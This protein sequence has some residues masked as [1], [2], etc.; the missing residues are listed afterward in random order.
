MV[1]LLLQYLVQNK[2]TFNVRIKIVR[3]P[4]TLR[5][6]YVFRR[7]DT[8]DNM[9]RCRDEDNNGNTNSAEEER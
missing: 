8:N 5:N 4:Q 1:G 3:P 2:L 9:A 6:L 7:S